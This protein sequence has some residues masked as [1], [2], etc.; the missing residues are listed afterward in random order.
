MGRAST[1]GTTAA[2][3][4]ALLACAG[5]HEAASPPAEGDRRG[6]AFLVLDLRDAAL[7]AH[8]LDAAAR[9]YAVNAQVID[10]DTGTV[11]LRGRE[12]IRA[13]HARFLD[14]CPAARIEVLDRAYGER[15]RYASDV[16]RVHCRGAAPVEG[17]VKY[18]IDQGTIV[19]VLKR[20]SPP[21]ER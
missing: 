21:F 5:P 13:A 7:A 8:D 19:R 6:Y 1:A 3:L 20:S 12:E 9:A 11:V 18:E 10:A 17:W 16:E 14:R 2:A 15:G 4:A